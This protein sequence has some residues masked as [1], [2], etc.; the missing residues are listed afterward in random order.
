MQRERPLKKTLIN[1]RA[2]YGFA[3]L[4]L[5]KN[6]AVVKRDFLNATS[7]L[8]EQSFALEGAPLPIAFEFLPNFDF[9]L[10]AMRGPHDIPLW[11]LGL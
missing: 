2:Y 7:N 5:G 11:R 3:S 9:G 8:S 1:T 6:P 4:A 10:G